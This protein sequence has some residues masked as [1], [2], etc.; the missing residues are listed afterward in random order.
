M[1]ISVYMP[2]DLV[3]NREKDKRGITRI[4]GTDQIMWDHHPLSTSMTPG[5]KSVLISVDKSH[6]GC[7]T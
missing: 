2:T 3:W 1:L 4:L 5:K 6:V 7:E